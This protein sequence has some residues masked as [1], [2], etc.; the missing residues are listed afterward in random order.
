MV[1]PTSNDVCRLEPFAPALRKRYSAF[2]QQVA[3]I[4][5]HE[6]GLARFA[7]GYKSMGLQVD[8]SGGV[9]YREWAPN[10]TEARLIG[11]FSGSIALITQ[12]NEAYY[13]WLSA[14]DWSHTA[15]P[16]KKSAFGIWECYVPPAPS[17]VCAIPHDS[18]IKISMTLPSG[19]SVD[20]IPTWLHRVTQD[21]NISPIYEGRFWNPPKEKQ[22]QFKNGHSQSHVDGLKIYEAHGTSMHCSA[23]P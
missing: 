13:L 21:L 4:E 23:N 17:G 14:D 16:M 9:R 7:E 19:L 10:A 8:S 12:L 3:A 1:I 11:E 15:N 22:Y 2:K 5:K 18:M 20:R 6:G